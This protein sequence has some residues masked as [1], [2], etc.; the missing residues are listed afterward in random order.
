MRASDLYPRL[1]SLRSLSLGLLR[2]C[3]SE[4][5]GKPTSAYL[6][7]LDLRKPLSPNAGVDLSPSYKCKWIAQPNVGVGFIPIFQ[8]QSPSN[9]PLKGENLITLIP[10][11]HVQ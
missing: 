10:S 2:A 3:L 5:L 1:R 11:I 8:G 4:A 6:D 9:S 7:A